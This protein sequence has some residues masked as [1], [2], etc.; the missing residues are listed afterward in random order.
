MPK[1]L[2]LVLNGYSLKFYRNGKTL[3]DGN[4]VVVLNLVL[5]GYSLKF[6]K[7]GDI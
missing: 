7:L 1:V 6:M 2:N 3:G 4:I 5:N